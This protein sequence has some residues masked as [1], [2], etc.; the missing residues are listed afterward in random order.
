VG[1]VRVAVRE[2]VRAYHPPSNAHDR[3]SAPVPTPTMARSTPE[4]TIKTVWPA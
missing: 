3:G 2:L 1:L 4:E